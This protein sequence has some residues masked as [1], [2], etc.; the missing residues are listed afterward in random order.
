MW[1]LVPRWLQAAGKL[2]LAFRAPIDKPASNSFTCRLEKRLLALRKTCWAKPMRWFG[3]ACIWLQH[4]GNT[5]KPGLFQFVVF[6]LSIPCGQASH[7]C[8]K[9]A[10]RIQLLRVRLTC[11]DSRGQS[12]QDSFLQFDGFGA[13]RLSVAQTYHRL[14]DTERRAKACNSSDDFG[15]TSRNHTITPTA[16][17]GPAVRA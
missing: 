17:V 3:S 12:A 13:E 1:Q 15:L 10:Y 5:S 4:E 2:A 6:R 9:R 16:G 8:F 14:R 7:F 11:L